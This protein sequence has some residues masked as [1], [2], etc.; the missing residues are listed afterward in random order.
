[1]HPRPKRRGILAKESKWVDCVE[2][3][4]EPNRILSDHT[5]ILEAEL[6]HPPPAL[7]SVFKHNESH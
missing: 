5:E 1:M 3:G 4:A 7:I 6:R 2:P